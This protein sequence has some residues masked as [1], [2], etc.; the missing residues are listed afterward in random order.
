MQFNRILPYFF[1]LILLASCAKTQEGDP[2]N[3]SPAR[4]ASEELETFQLEPGF[5]IQ[6]VAQEPMVQDPV[7]ITF[8][9]DAR[10]WVIEMRG[11]MT[12]TLGSEED[13]PIGRIS[14]LEDLDGD[15][16]MDKS[17]I[18][19]DSLIMP[20]AIGF[21]AD[22]VLV[23]ENTSL[24]VTQDLDGDLKADTQVLLDST[25]ASSGNPEHSDNGLLRNVDNWYYNAKSRLR[26]R[27]QN[28]DWIRDTTEFRG[29]WGISNDD[30]GRL[31]Y[32]YN[33]SQLHADLVPPNYFSRNPN[34]SPSTGIDH[35]V[36]LERAVY[37]IRET[38]AVNRGYIP[39][40]LS[41]DKRLMEF[42]AAC[43][44]WIYR[45][46]LFPEEFY[47]NAFVAEP[48]GNLVKRNVL[49]EAGNLVD[50]RDPHPGKEF[51]ASTD[52]RFR[53]VDFATGPDGALYI[54][55]MY[56]G[57]IQHGEY[58]TP[59]LTEQ[60]VG[61]GLVMPVH[62]GRIWKIVPE[63]KALRQTTRLS[64][65]SNTEL[66]EFLS[67]QDGW[68]RDMAQRLL[69]ERGNALV[70][71]ELVNLV[72]NQQAEQLGRFHGLWTLEGL[73]LLDE[74]LL[75]QVLEKEDDLLQN[76]AI[77]LLE[78]FAL[79]SVQVQ[80]RLAEVMKAAAK[81][82]SEAE[83][84][85][86]A[87]SSDVLSP[88]AQSDVLNSILA[89]YGSQAMI[90]DAMLSS[91]N[92]REFGL[93]QNLWK[94]SDWTAR[95]QNKEIF[96]EMLTTAVVKG[97]EAHEMKSLL[98]LADS[99]G[100]E[101]NWKQKILISGMS[102]QAANSKD[103]EPIVLQ[104]EPSLFSRTDLPID[105]SRLEMLRGMF[106]WPGYA[107]SEELT[108]ENQL[109]EGAMKQFALGRQKFLVGCAGC[110]GSDGAGAARMGPP[111][112]GSEWV[113]GDER[114]LAMILLHGLEGP[115]EVAGKTY[116]AP[117][118]LPVMPAHATMD[119]GSIAAILTYIR[120]EW[121]N[122][123]KPVSRR[124][125]SSTRLT[126]QGRVYPWSADELNEHMETLP[127]PETK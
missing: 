15:G 28:G 76:T 21:F 3:P 19:M 6:L 89:S 69:V 55:D 126:S 124:L 58:L 12:D 87:L 96:L 14:V 30:Q 24:W 108:A 47:G 67:D 16:Q 53:P 37:P 17:T 44:P 74:A 13:K 23:S 81:D 114:R 40:V 68:Y 113:T 31:Y 106:R 109:D 52:E 91:L 66:V 85:Q 71:N 62:L 46:T 35:G 127:P 5:K 51:L 41:E 88:Q 9:E 43:S 45:S 38:P 54:A 92:Q 112:V 75:F 1:V 123:A 49:M 65:K 59:Y 18:Y 80:N 93:M 34:H 118:I 120:N 61:R 86:L 107:P 33:W 42:T 97:G 82:A 64:D 94:A 77:R 73:G 101:L 50:G 4:A 70:K 111:L 103:H 79:R 99:P 36:A 20:R 116:D 102:I 57:L 60:T 7:F 117:D 100:S 72:L 104:T 84:L 78:P 63:G 32:N 115:I 11:F 8:D 83:A 27:Y 125:V 122:H 48:A 119:D 39:G 98:A 29:Q 105:E 25:Y 95:D 90:R 2:D 22:G 26:Y 56:R 110:H 121:G 10:L